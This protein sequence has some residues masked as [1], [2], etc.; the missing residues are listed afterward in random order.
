MLIFNDSG[1]CGRVVD[2]FNLFFFFGESFNL[3]RPLLII[4]LYHQTKTPISFWCKRG[5]N[6]KSLIQP[7]KTLPIELTETHGLFQ[8]ELKLPILK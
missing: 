3:W 8:S 6:P 7:S 2:Y 4:V 5:L 1:E